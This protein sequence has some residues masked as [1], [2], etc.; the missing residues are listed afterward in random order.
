LGKQPG[1]SSEELQ[2]IFSC[3]KRGLPDKDVLD[4][5]D[6]HEFPIRN[7]RFIRER[8]RHWEAVQKVL[9]KSYQKT[10]NPVITEQLSSHYLHL[11]EIAHALLENNIEFLTPVVT[12]N[13]SGKGIEFKGMCFSNGQHSEKVGTLLTYG[14]VSARLMKNL[15]AAYNK[16]GFL[17]IDENFLPH[18]KAE[19]PL[20]KANDIETIIQQKP[21]RLVVVLRLLSQRKTFK[22]KC[23]I[24]N[25][26]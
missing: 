2:F 22:G 16:F 11:A 17:D 7:V 5:M 26:W 3:F 4:E 18:L 21:A 12:S 23:P 8:R 10:F 19:L 15:K 6:G 13:E 14:E 20:V 9:D 25:D 24:C 1:A